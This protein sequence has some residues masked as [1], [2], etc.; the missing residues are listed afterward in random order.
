MCSPPRAILFD[1]QGTCTDFFTAVVEAARRIDQGR[2]P[3]ANWD[4]FIRGWRATYMRTLGND[5]AGRAAP[6]WRSVRGVYREAL[7]TLLAEHRI[8]GLDEDDRA[9][10]TLAWEEQPPW[11]DVVPGLARLRRQCTLGTL[12]NADTAAVI[13]TVRAGGLPFDV[14]FS[15]QM[16]QTFK[17]DPRVYSYA[18]DWLSLAPEEILL[19]ACHHY[20]LRAAGQLGFQTAF[21][22]R[23]LEFGPNGNPDITPDSSFALV[24]QDLLN[25]A[26]QLGA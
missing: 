24:A 22:P 6:A 4:V 16:F 8:D 13:S 26:D 12:S 1:L 19:V 10:L 7:D 11:P 25:L 17:P 20:D 21:I 9:A 3:D 14:L 15:A 23:P 5:E 2:H 18:A